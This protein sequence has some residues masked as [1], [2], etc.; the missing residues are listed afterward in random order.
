M[1][2][3]LRLLRA[4]TGTILNSR[5]AARQSEAKVVA[6]GDV[7]IWSNARLTRRQYIIYAWDET[8]G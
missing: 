3:A 7:N 4:F 5:R 1:T 6:A 2:A 8:Q